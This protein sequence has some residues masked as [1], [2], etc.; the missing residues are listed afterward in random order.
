VIR[1]DTRSERFDRAFTI[2]RVI[3]RFRLRRVLAA[4]AAF[5]L[6]AG[7][8][9]CGGEWASGRPQI[10]F[11]VQNPTLSF[12]RELSDG[13]RAGTRTVGGVD[14]VVTGPPVSDGVRQVDLFRELTT[15][16]RDGIAVAATAPALMAR[17][18]A[19]A[20]KDGT[21]LAT[22]D[23]EPAPGSGVKL[24][25]GNDNYELGRLLADE[26]I[27]RLP[28]NSTGK[29]VLGTLTPGVSNLDQR[30]KGMRDRFAEKLPTARVVGPFDTQR[31]PNPLPNLANW[32]F[33]VDA[34]RDAVVFLGTG[35]VDAYNLA[36]IRASTR[37]TWL[38]G[39]CGVDPRNLQGI[40]DG[41]LFASVSPEHYLMG[42]LAGRLLA[43]HA[44]GA[45]QLPEGWLVTPAQV[46]TSANVDEIIRRQAS[47]VVKSAWFQPRLD[48]IAGNPAPHLRP[49]DQAR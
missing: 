20:A 38:A 8:A 18:L 47:E 6:V 17:P 5:W 10:G 48:Q 34:N 11:V 39:S 12:G 30:A 45:K 22:V 21:P 14:A 16:A 44:R 43:E 49:L 31:D 23:A 37:G 40:K 28:P 26:A 13:Y 7:V 15:T 9:G 42:A 1:Q 24:Y 36:S 25:I 4:V 46:I 19:D 2:K 32:R 41:Q 3:M 29:V 27:K 33:L 35:D